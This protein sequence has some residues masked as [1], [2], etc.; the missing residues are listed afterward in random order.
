M[1]PVA[2]AAVHHGAQLNAPCWAAMA[3]DA[4]CT[5]PTAV[6]CTA[7]THVNERIPGLAS[8]PSRSAPVPA[9]GLR[10]GRQERHAALEVKRSVPAVKQA[11]EAKTPPAGPVTA[12]TATSSRGPVTRATSNS[13]ST[14]PRARHL[15]RAPR[16]LDA[17]DVKTLEDLAAIVMND[18]ELR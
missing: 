10:A 13:A 17:L 7:A 14:E 6:P 2:S 3:T 4:T 9:A 5:S 15:D 8:A 12:S 1:L 18:L 16:T 11:P